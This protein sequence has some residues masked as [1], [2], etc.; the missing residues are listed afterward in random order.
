MKKGVTPLYICMTKKEVRENSAPLFTGRFVQ[1]Y[2]E[3]E[4]RVSVQ[5]QDGEGGV[6]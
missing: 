4:G 6:Q 2:L 5:T 1:H 3:T